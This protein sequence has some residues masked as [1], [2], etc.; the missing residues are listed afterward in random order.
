MGVK[1]VFKKSKIFDRDG[2]YVILFVCLC[3][4][5]VAA[6]YITN[7]NN[8]LAKKQALV[9]QKVK[10]Q[11]P[12]N[13]VDLVDS[14]STAVP[15]TQE[16]KPTPTPNSN[17]K[18]DTQTS[19][20]QKSDSSTNKSSQSTS[21]KLVKPVSGNISRDYCGEDAKSAQLTY[22]QSMGQWETHEGIDFICDMGT[23]VKAAASGKVI[24]I[25]NNDTTLHG[26]KIGYGVGVVIEHDNGMRTVYANLAENVSVKVGDKVKAGQV[27]GKVGDT[28]TRE[29]VSIEGSHLHFALLKNPKNVKSGE[30]ASADPKKYFK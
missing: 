27:I 11:Q 9:G 14:G 26:D 15:T 24:Q 5:A 17:T 1:N 10:Q 13:N 12:I 28:S 29:S 23:E 19:K 6:V 20:D 8:K 16:P 30:I 4:V 22:S 7:N 25:T 21:F 3:I 18:K 2:F